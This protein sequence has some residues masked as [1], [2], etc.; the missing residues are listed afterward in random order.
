MNNFYQVV[1]CTDSKVFNLY[2]YG[3][4]FDQ[5][6][7]N[8]TPLHELLVENE[9]GV[10]YAV[11]DIYQYVFRCGLSTCG[12]L[13]FG[14]RPNSK[15]EFVRA[16]KKHWEHSYVGQPSHRETTGEDC[17]L[18][19][20]VE[21]YRLVQDPQVLGEQVV[22]SPRV[23]SKEGR[24]SQEV[25][26]MIGETR[27]TRVTKPFATISPPKMPVKEQWEVKS[28]PKEKVGGLVKETEELWLCPKDDCSY[29]GA[30]AAKMRL[31]LSCHG[32]DVDEVESYAREEMVMGRRLAKVSR[33]VYL[34]KAREILGSGPLTKASGEVVGKGEVWDCRVPECCISFPSEENLLKHCKQMHTRIIPSAEPLSSPQQPESGATA[35]KCLH[36]REIVLATVGSPRLV[37]HWRQHLEPLTSMRFLCLASSQV[38]TLEDVHPYSVE[39]GQPECRRLFTSDVSFA[40]VQESVLTHWNASHTGQPHF[41]SL[42]H[43]A[44]AAAS[45]PLKA[46][47]LNVEASDPLKLAGPFKCCDC[48]QELMNAQ[49]VF[50]HSSSQHSSTT[51]SDLQV[52]VNLCCCAKTDQTWQICHCFMF[53]TGVNNNP[54]E[55]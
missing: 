36:C 5:A 20:L 41:S 38:L 45:S 14:V 22:A 6:H 30:T 39:C 54:L 44:T 55:P 43:R 10:E 37:E 28:S 31:H 32:L 8:T 27:V 23:R 9:K 18:E 11:L 24:K 48:D 26:G 19:V 13:F 25:V 35:Y 50:Q 16:A 7:R 17:K 40:Q 29:M 2:D 1:G 34:G 46:S 15:G 47:L 52:N 4:H 51:L 3:K 33:I 53:G 12:Q 21:E 42:S 49:A